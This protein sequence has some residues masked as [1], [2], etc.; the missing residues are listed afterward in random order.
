[1]NPE[2]K[3]PP[4][5]MRRELIRRTRTALAAIEPP[6]R[7]AAVTTLLLHVG[8]DLKDRAGRA[9]WF[10]WLQVLARDQDGIEREIRKLDRLYARALAGEGEAAEK[11]ALSRWHRWQRRL[12]LQ[13]LVA[14]LRLYTAEIMPTERRR[15]VRLHILRACLRIRKRYGEEVWLAWLQR[16]AAEHPTLYLAECVRLANLRIGAE[17]AGKG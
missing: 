8:S 13:T 11:E 5:A 12:F 15:A 4:R 9:D 10:L 14:H 1:M 17:F 3:T 6:E 2:A 16:T 7:R